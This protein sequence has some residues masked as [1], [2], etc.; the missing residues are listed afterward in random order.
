M[1]DGGDKLGVG[2][3]GAALVAHALDHRFAHAVHLSGQHGQ[4]VLSLYRDRR[5]QIPGA[6][7]VGLLGQA[8]DPVGQTADVPKHDGEE[9]R[10]PEDH[11]DD[12]VDV[13]LPDIAAVPDGDT[14]AAVRKAHGIEPAVLAVVLEP[15]PAARARIGCGCA[16]GRPV[17]LLVFVDQDGHIGVLPCPVGHRLGVRAFDLIVRDELIELRVDLRQAGRAGFRAHVELLERIAA[18]PVGG[19]VHQRRAQEGQQDHIQHF[20]VQRAGQPQPETGFPLS[21]FDTLFPRRCGG[22]SDWRDSPRSSGAR[23]ARG[24]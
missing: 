3:P 17:G 19:K 24:P 2:L 1:G 9:G 11:G 8:D 14:I 21:Q 4:L 7:I 10:A 16:V 12:P 13:V 23:S 18:Q 6:D 15:L 22:S 20:L 5:L